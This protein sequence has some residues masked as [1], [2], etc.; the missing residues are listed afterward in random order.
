VW[1][2]IKNKAWVET[3]V[4]ISDFFFVDEGVCEPNEGGITNGENSFVAGS[5]DE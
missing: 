4:D 5:K 1:Y 2:V 3:P